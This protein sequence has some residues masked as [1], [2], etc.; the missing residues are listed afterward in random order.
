MKN[1]V[2]VLILLSAFILFCMV[3]CR[4]HSVP[5]DP[6]ATHTPS[7][8][9]TATPEI[10]IETGVTRGDNHGLQME[11]FVVVVM[12]GAGATLNTA[13]ITMTGPT[14]VIG[15]PNSQG[16]L[17]YSSFSVVDCPNGAQFYVSVTYN[18]VN[19][20]GTFTFPGAINIAADG[21]SVS[22]PYTATYVMLDLNGPSGTSKNYGPTVITSPFN[23]A[24]TGIF[25]DG[26]G[27]YDI[28][29]ETILLDMNSGY[30]SY[31]KLQSI[32]ILED[33]SWQD[34]TR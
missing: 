34:I 2:K 16:S 17:N 12:D 27:T 29:V 4:N 9:G 6:S 10:I 26:S 18:A 5:T 1:M 20:T 30:M 19:Y 28:M 32:L 31:P 3:G 13:S 7:V 15:L 24:S 14:G 25:S 21:S 8:S 11:Q 23:V 33:M 22:W